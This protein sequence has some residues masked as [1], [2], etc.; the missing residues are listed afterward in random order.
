MTVRVE[1]CPHGGPDHASRTAV[2]ILGRNQFRAH[3]DADEWQQFRAAVK[4]GEFDHINP[5]DGQPS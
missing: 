1:K 2:D 3:V 4:R 5:G